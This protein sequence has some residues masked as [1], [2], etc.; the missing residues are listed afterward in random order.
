MIPMFVIAGSARTHATSPSASAASRASG[1]FHSIAFV[2]TARSTGG[3][4]LSGRERVSP[5]TMIAKVSST[6]PW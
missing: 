2:V 3:P 1:S 5:S 6:V 4:T